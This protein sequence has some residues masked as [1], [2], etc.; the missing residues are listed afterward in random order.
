MILEFWLNS[1]QKSKI[2]N[3]SCRYP[4]ANGGS[5]SMVAAGGSGAS[6]AVA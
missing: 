4:P 2:I 5:T 6:S 3:G 1:D